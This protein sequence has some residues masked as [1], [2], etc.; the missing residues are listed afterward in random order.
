MKRLLAIIL[1]V[2]ILP[3]CADCD[4][5]GAMQMRQQL[6]QSEGCSFDVEITADYGDNVHIFGM[7]CQTDDLG[8][9]TFSVSEP[10]SISGITGT[11]RDEGG[12]L[13]FDDT[14]LAFELLADDQITP[15]SAP[16]ILIRT[17]RSGYLNACANTDDGIMLVIDDSY[18]EDALK[19]NIWCTDEYV[20]TEAEIFWEGRRILTLEISNFTYL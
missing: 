17:L 6:Q 3:G 9:L 16:W 12:Q 8:N 20:P 7:K 2:L 18:A 5:D 13:T 1:S 11:I 14:V 4:L 15:V 19:L 10:D